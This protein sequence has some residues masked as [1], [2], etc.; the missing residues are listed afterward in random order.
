MAVESRSNGVLCALARAACV[1]VGIMAV[2]GSGGGAVGFPSMDWGSAGVPMPPSVSAA[3]NPYP[4][5]VQAGSIVKFEVSVLNAEPPVTYQWRR[6]RVPI[7]GATG[8]SYT[9]GGAQASDDGAVF[10]V[11]V[12]APNGAAMAEASLRVSPYPPL[13]WQDDDWVAAGW[14]AVA[15]SAS[16]PVNGPEHTVSQASEGGDPGAHR[17]IDYRV[18]AGPTSLDLLHLRSDATYEPARQGEIYSIELAMDCNIRAGSTGL[19]YWNDQSASPAFEQAG[20]VYQPRDWYGTC[21]SAWRLFSMARLDAADFA[22][23]SGPACGSGERCP[24]FSAAGAPLRFGFVTHVSTAPDSATAAFTQGIDNW[25]VT[26]WR[27]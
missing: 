20:R 26:V 6:D 4:A 11:V 17:R 25:K 18:P 15:L 10:D 19:V 27:R 12:T 9:L 2:V 7:A 21:R 8:P 14:S 16:P 13:V 5:T 23:Q 3:M 24:D 22:R 1:A